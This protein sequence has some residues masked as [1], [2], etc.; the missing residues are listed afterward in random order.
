MISHDN[1]KVYV[2]SF[3]E[4]FFTFAIFCIVL[5]VLYPKDLLENK[6]LVEEANYDL[7]ILYLKDLLKHDPE[8]EK[9]MLLLAQKGLKSGKRDL[10]VRL[11]NLLHTSENLKYRKKSLLLSYQL[12]KDDYFYLTDRQRK[13]EQK[14]R[15]ST[16]FKQIIEQNMY[17]EEELQKW[18]EESV[19]LEKDKISYYLL[20]RL[21]SNDQ[22]NISYLEQ[23]YYLSIKL[24][25][26]NDRVKYL[27]LLITHDYKRREKWKD[28]YY[29][30]LNDKKDNTTL[31]NFLLKESKSS[32][33]WKKRLIDFYILNK[34]YK[35]ASG[36]Y[37]DL[38]MMVKNYKQKRR[39]FYK[40]V[41]ILR[42]GNLLKDSARLAHRF[43]NYF[44]HDKKVRKFLL[45]TYLSTGY[46]NYAAKLSDKILKSGLY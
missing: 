18:Y 2:M 42:A 5:F 31:L 34:K 27:K 24:Q 39:Y 22:Y 12:N 44:F 32:L 28:S 20:E 17:K 40:A 1:E 9:L 15:L 10:S 41:N 30:F 29:Y 13:I 6:I 38:L 3:K 36:V 35:K 14:K 7:S 8:N 11:L 21:L 46:L 37:I 23:I 26:D 45:R 33:K 16:I 19:F 4:L 43:E 25:R